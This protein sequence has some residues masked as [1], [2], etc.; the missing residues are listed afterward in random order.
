MKKY[1][2]DIYKYYSSNRVDD[3]IP[4][5]LKG[6]KPRKP[7]FDYI[8]KNFFPKN[9]NSRIIEIGCGHGAFQYFIHKA[10]YKNSIGVDGSL[11]QVS[12][13]K[14]LGIDSVVYG[15]LVEYIKRLEN[16]TVD[17]LV[18]IDVIEHFTKE[19][20][21]DLVKEMHRILKKDGLVITHQPNGDSIFS[22]GVIYG[23]LTHEMAFTQNSISQLFLSCG[24][25]KIDSY[26]DR[27][28]VHGVKSFIRLF[29]WKYII[30]KIYIAI[31]IV[32]TGWC[33][34]GAI[35]SLNFV[36]IAKK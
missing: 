4:K 9:R 19:E 26:E 10:G 16:D 32:E 28:V 29:L 35:F 1:R 36:S 31:R 5:N 8:I 7:F 33:D 6:L 25:G 12:G 34:K 21:S 30:R 23:D 17:L 24:F 14:K 2:E 15:D 18:A 11:E 20:L 13:A 22:N 3:I 27:P